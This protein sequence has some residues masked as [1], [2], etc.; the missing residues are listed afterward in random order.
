MLGSS[1]DG[2]VGIVVGEIDV[3]LLL[4]G[5]IEPAVVDA[6]GYQIDVFTL[7][8]AGLDGRVLRLKVTGK[9]WGIMPPITLTKDPLEKKKLKELTSLFETDGSKL[10]ELTNALLSY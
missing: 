1:D 8:T 3:C 7:H 9:F 6:K 10:R 5:G 4:N 2:L